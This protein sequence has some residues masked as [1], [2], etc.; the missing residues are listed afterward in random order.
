MPISQQIGSSS[1]AKPGVCTSSTRPASPYQGQV[2]YQTDTNTTLVWN[3]SG[4]VLL[5]TGTANPPGLELIT[6]C[7]VSSTGGTAA[8]VSNGVITVGTSNTGITV[9]NAFSASFDAYRILLTGIVASSSSPNCQFSLSGITGSVYYAAGN[10]YSWANTT[11]NNYSPAANTFCVIGT[12]GTE[13]CGIILDIHNPF[14][15]K[16]KFG[17]SQS[18]DVSFSFQAAHRISSTTSATGFVLGPATGSWTG[19]TI[20]VYGYRNS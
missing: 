13:S 5:S 12:I 9:S 17:Y 11:I 10:Y 18:S 7:T 14:L 19:G 15:T 4:W 20:R 6:A 2:I 3:G 16:S 1:L 8:T